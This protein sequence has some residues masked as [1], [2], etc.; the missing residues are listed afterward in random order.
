MDFRKS[1]AKP[2]KKL[3][4]KFPWG[5]RKRDGSGGEDDRKKAAVDIEGGEASQRNSYLRSGV[6]VEGAVES[7]PHREGRNVDRM[8]AAL[9]DDPP[10]SPPS[11][12]HIEES[13]STWTSFASVLPLIGSSRQRGSFRCS[14]SSPRCSWSR[15]ERTKGHRP[16][17]T[18]GVEVHCI[19]NSQIIPPCS[20]RIRGC[21]P[22][23]Q[24]CGWR[25]LLYSG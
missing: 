13:Q 7:G 23:A 5:S 19:C 15:P 1:L 9:V 21:L 22:P 14:R 2:F 12:S 16:G 17:Q 10:T 25:S 24:I 4:N 6:S 3:K 20:E 11:I 18:R 8:E